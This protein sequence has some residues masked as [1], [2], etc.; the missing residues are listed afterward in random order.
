MA[1]TRSVGTCLTASATPIAPIRIGWD[2]DLQLLRVDPSLIGLQQFT[3][4]LQVK[5]HIYGVG[6]NCNKED[7]PEQTE[8]RISEDDG[9]FSP[10][11][12]NSFNL[13]AS[14]TASAI[15]VLLM[16]GMPFAWV[17]KAGIKRL[18]THEIHI[19]HCWTAT[20]WVFFALLAHLPPTDCTIER[21]VWYLV[22]RQTGTPAQRCGWDWHR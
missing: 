19:N 20:T 16:T 9:P 15:I 18:S 21:E 2:L 17:Y 4:F 8:Y 5:A 12:Q 10:E 11:S 22:T 7:Q 14:R 13:S 6:K 1:A 3:P